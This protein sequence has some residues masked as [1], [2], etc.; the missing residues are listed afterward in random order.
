MFIWFTLPV[1]RERLSVCVY[2]SFPFNSE[3]LRWVLVVLFPN[4]CRSFDFVPPTPLEGSSDLILLKLS[5][6][7]CFF[8]DVHVN[9]YFWF[10]HF[11]G[12]ELG[13]SY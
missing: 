5:R 8:E 12:V 2:A 3:G 6:F 10:D 9:F 1:F 13:V 4:H 11:D 7:S